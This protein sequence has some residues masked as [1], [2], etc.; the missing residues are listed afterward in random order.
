[1]IREGLSRH[2]AGNITINC[3]LSTCHIIGLNILHLFLTTVLP[4]C[5]SIYAFFMWALRLIVVKYTRQRHFPIVC[6]S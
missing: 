6:Q 3:L 1:M 5:N 2:E 4:V